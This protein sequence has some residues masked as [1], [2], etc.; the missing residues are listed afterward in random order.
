MI[1]IDNGTEFLNTSLTKNFNE[2]GIVHQRSIPY[3]PQQN[4][5]V[6]RKRRHLIETAQTLR[7][8]VGLPIRKI[9]VSRDVIF[10]EKNLSF[11]LVVEQ[12]FSVSPPSLPLVNPAF[13]LEYVPSLPSIM[14][15][16]ESE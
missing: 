13:I 8:H 1:R 6:K 10:H 3:T 2:Q 9:L 5:R 12:K 16:K 14:E 11:K 4:S 15:S 7:L